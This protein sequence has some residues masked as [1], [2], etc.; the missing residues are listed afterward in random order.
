MTPN[1]I[2]IDAHNH[3]WSQLLGSHL[4]HALT[5]SESYTSDESKDHL[6][7][8]RSHVC[9]WLGPAPKA[10]G[11]A[12]HISAAYP[13]ALTADHT[14]CEISYGW[15]KGQ[16][17]TTVRYV[18]DMIPSNA[19]SGRIASLAAASR[20]IDELSF[21]AASASPGVLMSPDLW[22]AVTAE[23][24]KLE[25]EIHPVD[26]PSCGPCSSSSAFIGFDLI[27]RGARAKLYWLL[28]ACLS[29]TGLLDLLDV[30]FERCMVDGHLTGL[31]RFAEHWAQVR[32]YL[33]INM[34]G[35]DA[36]RPRMLS[37]DASH[38]PIPRVKLYNR[39]Y[40]ASDESFDVMKSHLALG[41]EIALQPQTHDEYAA[42]WTCVQ[43]NNRLHAHTVEE[44]ERQRYCMVAYDIFPAPGGK[45][46][47]TITSKLYLFCD[48]L[49]GHDAF[50]TNELLAKFPAPADFLR[51]E[52]E[53]GRLSERSTHIKEVGLTGRDGVVDIAA[54]ISPSI[55]T[56]KA[57]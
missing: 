1:P 38:H 27:R 52:F 51:R 20:A 28:P 16:G 39:Y 8:F 40:F 18:V 45:G 56:P 37:L 13:S 36:L 31:P 24:T 2:D 35:P 50:V 55:F 30:V 41:G 21:L 9:R 29:P 32:H 10:N 15:K 34:H 42:L 57:T 26:R 46:N 6:D 23:M 44:L 17:P 43:E 4:E 53:N 19:K 22:A 5:T 11:N 54:Y 12:E 47:N 25:H 48:Q 14:P 49:P 33:S 7:F 3:E